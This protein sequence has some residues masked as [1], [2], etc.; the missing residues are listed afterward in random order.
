MSG[1]D[2]EVHVG[3]RFNRQ[4]RGSVLG[5][6]RSDALFWTISGMIL[7][8]VSL[9]FKLAAQVIPMDSRWF[10]GIPLDIATNLIPHPISDPHAMAQFPRRVQLNSDNR[11]D[12][13]ASSTAEFHTSSLF[14]FSLSVSLSLLS[15][16]LAS[17]LC[18][19]LSRLHLPLC[20]RHCP[21]SGSILLLWPLTFGSTCSGAVLVVLVSKRYLAVVSLLSFNLMIITGESPKQSVVILLMEIGKATN[22]FLWVHRLKSPSEI[23]FSGVFNQCPELLFLATG[24]T[25]GKL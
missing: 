23:S 25:M 4:E 8:L 3:M 16:N 12:S 22:I 9:R 15:L 13:C 20:Q 7:T 21:C 14:P 10:S 24:N 5:Y 1:S 6:P 17:W 18:Q 2:S 19:Y 11:R